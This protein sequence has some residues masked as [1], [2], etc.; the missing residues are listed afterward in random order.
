M[1]GE[2]LDQGMQQNLKNF[3]RSPGT[4]YMCKSLPNKLLA[5]LYCLLDLATL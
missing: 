1:H 3:A 4:L 5:P 2:K